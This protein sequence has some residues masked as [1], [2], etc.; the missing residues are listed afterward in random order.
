V[1]QYAESIRV[2]ISAEDQEAHVSILEERLDE[3]PAAQQRRVN[4]LLRSF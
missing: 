4:K 1:P 2:A 3:L